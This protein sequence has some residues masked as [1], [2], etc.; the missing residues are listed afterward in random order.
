MRPQEGLLRLFVSGLPAN[1]LARTVE[2]ANGL[3]HGSAG[4]VEVAGCCL[5]AEGALSRYAGQANIHQQESMSP[6][7]FATQFQ[8]RFPSRDSAESKIL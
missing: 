6:L 7:M 5:E 4:L 3:P 1:N 8:E 2:V